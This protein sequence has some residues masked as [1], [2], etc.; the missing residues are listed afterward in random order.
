MHTESPRRRGILATCGV[1]L[2]ASNCFAAPGPAGAQLTG[3]LVVVILVI[4]STVG[5]LAAALVLSVLTPQRIREGSRIL[6]QS[7]LKTFLTG[8]L[9]ALISILAMGI[10]DAVSK[11]V[12]VIFWLPLLVAETLLLLLGFAMVGHVVGDRIHTNTGS[13]RAGSSF[14]AVLQGGALLLALAFLPFVG[15]V[16]LSVV[17]MLCLGAALRA[18]V[19]RPTHDSGDVAIAAGPESEPERHERESPAD[20]L[21]NGDMSEG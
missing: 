14:M 8:V 6:E 17:A 12:A 2:A 21:G 5:L 19:T 20:P 7:P 4:C 9:I 3:L 10:L 11:P 18:C 13:F 15:W 1:L 16:I